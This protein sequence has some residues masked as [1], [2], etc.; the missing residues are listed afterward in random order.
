MVSCFLLLFCGILFARKGFFEIMNNNYNFNRFKDESEL[1]KLVKAIISG[2]HNVENLPLTIK[3][4]IYRAY[5]KFGNSDMDSELPEYVRNSSHDDAIPFTE[6]EQIQ[7][8]LI[9][10][11][12]FKLS[13]SDEDINHFSKYLLNSPEGRRAFFYLTLDEKES[14]ENSSKKLVRLTFKSDVKNDIFGGSVLVLFF[15]YIFT[16]IHNIIYLDFITPLRKAVEDYSFCY[17]IENKMNNFCQI[18]VFFSFIQDFFVQYN[19]LIMNETSIDRIKMVGIFVV[20]LSIV[21]L[22]VSLD[23][24]YP[25]IYGRRKFGF[26]MSIPSKFERIMWIL[27]AMMMLVGMALFINVVRILISFITETLLISIIGLF[28]F[29]YQS[30]IAKIVVGFILALVFINYLSSKMDVIYGIKSLSTKDKSK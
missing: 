29:L 12:E 10:I 8:I 9:L 2:T 16:L 6:K 5:E 24:F 11:E 25:F 1:G 30:T 17:D 4:G 15:S 22:L 20:C 26:D 19:R 21:Y 7:L 27:Y 28:I 14:D 3:T 23:D 18:N 13:Y